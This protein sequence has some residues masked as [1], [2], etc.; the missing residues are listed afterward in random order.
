MMSK[1]NLYRGLFVGA[2]SAG[3]AVVAGRLARR[4]ST[5]GAIALPRGRAVITGAS[6]G[7]G[8]EFARQLAAA[9]FDLTL[10]ARRADR[11]Q[12]LA[13]AL[14][15]A[16]GI[17]ADVW[18]ADLTSEAEV[19]ALADR[20]AAADDLVLLV[21]NAGFGSRGQFA[22]VPLERTLDMIRVHVLAT[23]ALSRAAVP[24]MIAR[25]RG[26][27]I[28]VSSIAAFFPTA[29]GATY[30]ATKV[31]LNNFSQAL[32][33]ELEGT[34]VAVQ[35][36]CPGFTLTEFHDVGDYED[37]DRGLLPGVVWMTP[38][39]V[40]GE[41]LAA[42]GSGDVIV[43]PGAKYKVLVATASGP[44]SGTVRRVARTVRRHWSKV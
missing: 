18:P 25:G 1:K 30:S 14:C 34:G 42:L 22:D 33:A 26:A 27:I 4:A 31:Y 23:V 8:A 41:S 44:F 9:G 7:I 6:A 24:G 5:A 19:A 40:V 11:L 10:V 21:N 29:G 20:L 16:H 15:V 3:G 12:A 38:A 17:R 28:N 35:A 32:T 2:L 39:A 36:L 37:F 43:V 13:D